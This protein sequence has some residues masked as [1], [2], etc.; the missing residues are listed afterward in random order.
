MQLNTLL[1]NIGTNHSSRIIFYGGVA[2]AI[3][4]ASSSIGTWLTSNENSK[5]FVCSENEKVVEE[6]EKELDD[7][8]YDNL[9]KDEEIKKRKITNL[10]EFKNTL[11]QNEGENHKARTQ[12]VEI[13]ERLSGYITVDGNDIY[14]TPVLHSRSS[15][16]FT[17]KLKNSQRE[18]ILDYMI[19]KI[20]KLKE[21]NKVLIDELK[22][23]KDEVKKDNEKEKEKEKEK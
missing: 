21:E 9:N 11:N 14:F 1:A 10:H 19:S 6:R 20:D 5:L 4:E 18:I 3:R 7:D 12:F 2:S 17:Y 13:S 8:V 16:T 15:Q 22:I 23:I